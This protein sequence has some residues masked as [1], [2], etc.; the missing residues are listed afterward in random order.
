MSSSFYLRCLAAVASV[1]IMACADS[2]DAPAKTPVATAAPATQALNIA[3]KNDPNP[4][5][6]G[7][8]TV[9]VTVIN[10]DGSP[11]NDATV[12][13]TFYMPAMPSM[14]MPE[15]RSVFP[16][17]SEGNGRYRGTGQL[18][19]SGTWEVTVNVSRGSEKLG[20]KKLT[21]IAK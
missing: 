10:A 2:A 13:A 3:F 12:A 14:S 17:K 15:M 7:D 9:E 1:S 11:L 5:R 6:S 21:V 8:N 16:L 19:M 4:P 20:S 18:V